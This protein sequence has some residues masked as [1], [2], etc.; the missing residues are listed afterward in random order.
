MSNV[1]RWTATLGYG[2]SKLLVELL[3]TVIGTIF[4]AIHH[5]RVDIASIALNV[6]SNSIATLLLTPW[7]PLNPPVGLAARMKDRPW[8]AVAAAWH[9]EL[10]GSLESGIGTAQHL[11]PSMSACVSF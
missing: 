4:S 7:G 5:C 10:K 6:V 3:D 2:S 9:A 11:E 1:N 8:S